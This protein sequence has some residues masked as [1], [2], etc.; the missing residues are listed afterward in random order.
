MKSAGD[1]ISFAAEFTASVQYRIHD[2][3]RGNALCGVH[4]RRD[5]SSVVLNGNA[6]SGV[7][8]DSYKVAVTCQ[9]LVDRVIHYLVHKVMQT[10][11]RRCAYIHTGALADR[12]KSL[13]HLYLTFRIRFVGDDRIKHLVLRIQCCLC[14]FYVQLVRFRYA[15]PG[16]FDLISLISHFF[17]LV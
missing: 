15:F 13:K 5:A 2:L 4:A 8:R 12:F 3:G 17:I 6:L 7:Y 14:R 10:S 9:R 16:H 1:L 11:H